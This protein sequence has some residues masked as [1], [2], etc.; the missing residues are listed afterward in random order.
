MDDTVVIRPLR[1]MDAEAVVSLYAEVAAVEPR[2]GPIS[3]SQWQRF[4]KLPQNNGCR[5]FRVAELDGRLVGLAESS[6][7]IQGALGLRFLKIVVTPGARRQRIGLRLF[8]EALALD[9][10][11]GDV[12]VKTLV[13]PEWHSGMEFVSAL[14]FAHLESEI[15][16]RCTEPMEPVQAAGRVAV[17]RAGDAAPYA[18]DVARIHNLAYAADAS[19]RPYSPAEMALVLD[20]Y[21]LWIVSADSRLAGFC[22]VE[23]EHDSLWIESIA[24][25]PARQ[26]RG[27]GKTLLFYVL[28]AHAVSVNYPCWLSVSS[29]NPMA[30][31]M[32]RHLGF[33][34]QHETCRFSTTRR[35]LIAARARRFG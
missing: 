14:G 24:V 27:L 25:D 33:K 21:E 22:L 16:M 30:L 2:L 13:S 23:P 8:D 28:D 7:R 3:L 29:K 31:S 34:P 26:A 35:E 15:S 17:E 32:Y 20:D 19:F 10:P 5:D 4:T 18:A 1:E 9:D 11:G 6:L 12:T